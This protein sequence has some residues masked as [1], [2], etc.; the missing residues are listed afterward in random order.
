MGAG[1][2]GLA[3]PPEGP[4]RVDQT[5][6]LAAADH[7]FVHVRPDLAWDADAALAPLGDRATVTRDLD[8]LVARVTAFAQPG[9]ALIVMSN[10]DFG[11]V[12]RRLLDALASAA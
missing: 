6:A 4:A 1:R 8:E 10:G 2:G 12:H 5:G 3:G 11:G 7:S 9:D